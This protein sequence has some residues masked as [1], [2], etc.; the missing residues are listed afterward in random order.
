VFG[1]SGPLV[2]GDEIGV[3]IG[4]VPGVSKLR[5]SEL[6]SGRVLAWSGGVPGVLAAVHAF[7]FEAREGGSMARSEE[8]WSGALGRLGPL[9]KRVRTQAE[10]VGADQLAGLA[11]AVRSQRT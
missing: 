10:R 2:V 8:R 3:R 6:E 4:G 7:R 11:D 9:A 5:I 1:P